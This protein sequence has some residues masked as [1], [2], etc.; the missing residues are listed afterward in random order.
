M[1]KRTTTLLMA[2]VL[3]VCAASLGAQ[4]NTFAA[5]AGL[6][7][8]G[9]DWFV[10]P[11]DW[12]AIENNIFIL[13]LNTTTLGAGVGLHLGGLYVGG[14][15]AGNIL[16][17]ASN[18]ATTVQLQ[19]TLLLNNNQIIGEELITT[20]SDANV[21]DS[22][23]N[24]VTLLFGVGGMG[25]R[26]R[27]VQTG[28]SRANRFL[29]IGPPDTG[30]TAWTDLFSTSITVTS[31][32]LT[33]VTDAAGTLTARS[34]TVYTGGEDTLST[35]N[36]SIGWGMPID[37]GDLVLRPSVFVGAAFVTDTF[38]TTLTDYTQAIGSGFPTYPA[39]DGIT[40]ILSHS[41]EAFRYGSGYIT[42][43][44]DL[45]AEL[46][47]PAESGAVP[48]IVFG[49]GLDVN[50]FSNGYNDI[51]GAPQTIAGYAADYSEVAY[52]RDVNGS[53][54]TTTR[55]FQTEARTNM[56]HTIMPGFRYTTPITEQLSVGFSAGADVTLQATSSARS[57]GLVRT[58]VVDSILD[59]AQDITTTTTKSYTGNAVQTTALTVD[60]N[61][62][63]GLQFGIVPGVLVLNAGATVALPEIY[64]YVSETTQ[65][66]ITTR[67]VQAV[68][69]TGQ[70]LT[71]TYQSTLGSQRTETQVS[72]FDWDQ[73]TASVRGG[74]TFSLGGG[75]VLDLRM[76]TG[77]VSGNDV[78]T[79]SFTAQLLVE[80]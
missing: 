24:T 44:G 22:S 15:F 51:A 28:E 75:F 56:T 9:A 19:S 32:V 63:F 76:V 25:L 12:L 16:N 3:L 27:L 49:Y 53:T 8:N 5:T 43:W 70:V 80:R 57:G 11:T 48:I 40:E 77:M 7:E 21:T 37:L 72:T 79:T 67:T 2:V 55:A 10:S 38:A 18:P 1:G 65:P 23:N 4:S 54:L 33:D 74:L 45:G 60:P 14:H 71:D 30:T 52:T 66:G 39:T 20:T 26:A 47:L 46:E 13:D 68:D 34:S 41:V 35:L 59:L 50:L 42:L 61:L 36:P 6:F 78:W 31:D 73:M 58:V 64:S 17:Q 69:G 29:M 62:G